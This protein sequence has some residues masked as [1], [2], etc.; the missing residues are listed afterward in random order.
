MFKVGLRYLQP[1]QYTVHGSLHIVPHGLDARI[2]IDYRRI[3]FGRGTEQT[4]AFDQ[5]RVILVDDRT[6]I[7]V[8]QPYIGGNH[9]VCILRV[10]HIITQ[11]LHQSQLGSI[12]GQLLFIFR[13]LLQSQTGIAGQI[14]QSGALLEIGKF[15]F[16]ST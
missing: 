6:Q 14:G 9:L 4:L 16:G 1:S 12:L 3:V 8:L 13:T 7:L 10:V 15:R 2:D 11:R 5:H